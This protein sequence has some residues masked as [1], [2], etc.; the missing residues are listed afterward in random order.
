LL[1]AAGAIDFVSARLSDDNNQA[2]C[3][4]PKGALPGVYRVD[5]SLNGGYQYEP[6]L[7]ANVT[8]E[9]YDRANVVVDSVFPPGGPTTG[10]TTLTVAGSGFVSYGAFEPTCVLTDSSGVDL[11]LPGTVLAATGGNPQRLLCV[12]PRTTADAHGHQLA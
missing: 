12:T 11:V 10:G 3:A 7:L 4:T 8:F 9:L 6:V 2:V 1:G 5:L